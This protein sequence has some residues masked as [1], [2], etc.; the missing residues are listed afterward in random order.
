MRFKKTYIFG[1]ISLGMMAFSWISSTNVKAENGFSVVQK[2]RTKDTSI[3]Y[4]VGVKNIKGRVS[5]QIGREQ[6]EDI[7]MQYCEQG[8]NVCQTLVLVDNSASVP[9]NRR[10]EF[11]KILYGIISNKVPNEKVCLATFNSKIKYLSKYTDD[12]MMLNRAVSK[13]TY[14]TQSTYLT[15]VLYHVIG[16]FNDSSQNNF[17]RIIILSDGFDNKKFGVTKEELMNQL[18]ETPYYISTIGCDNGDNEKDLKSM[19]ALSRSTNAPSFLLDDENCSTA[20]VINSMKIEN[21]FVKFQ[22]NIP[23]DLRDGSKKSVI[24][25]ID[26]G[27]QFVTTQVNMPFYS[28]DDTLSDGKNNG[29]ELSDFAKK[30]ILSVFGC[31]GVFLI[32]LYIIIVKSKKNF[33]YKRDVYS[34]IANE[35]MKGSVSPNPLLKIVKEY[36]KRIETRYDRLIEM[37]SDDSDSENVGTSSNN[38]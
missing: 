21:K 24:I 38:V 6:V 5:C 27:I 37:K 36:D 22:I 10:L 19:F 14:A 4:A 33:I 26:N 1:I 28:K 12:K 9:Q 16:R 2:D 3:I 7:S 32:V 18:R 34:L 13:I 25:K 30:I 29:W 31:L 17:K 15:D 11:K 23:Q 8:D 35:Y 20:K